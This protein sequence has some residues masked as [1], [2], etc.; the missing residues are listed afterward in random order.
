[1]LARLLAA[2]DFLSPEQL[3]CQ[4]DVCWDVVRARNQLRPWLWPI[5]APKAALLA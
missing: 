4:C 1:M 5:T 2:V 3:L